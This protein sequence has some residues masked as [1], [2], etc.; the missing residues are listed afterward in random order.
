MTLG[1]RCLAEGLGTGVLVTLGCGAIM[2]ADQTRA[3]GHVGIA[4]AFGLAVAVVVGATGHLGG[5]HINPAVTIGLWATGRHPRREVVPYVMAQ[6]LGAVAASA[7]LGWLLGPV[8]SGGATLPSVDV[9]R[10][11]VIE[12]G[13]T[14]L[15]GLVIMGVSLDPRGPGSLAPVLLGLTVGLGAL[16]TGPLTGGSF[17]PARSFGPALMNGVWR[18]HWLYWVAPT[19]GMIAGLK[20]YDALFALRPSVTSPR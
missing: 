7:L 3:F 13:F 6:L 1:R 11:A 9:A 5:A 19:L 17:N 16:V 10:A 18:T 4:M 12:A 2:V 20:G 14:A 8:A 15:L